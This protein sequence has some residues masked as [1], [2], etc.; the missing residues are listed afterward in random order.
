MV[1][2]HDYRYTCRDGVLTVE[3]GLFQKSPTLSLYKRSLSDENCFPAPQGG[4]A[5]RVRA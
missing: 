3:N 4:A 5:L 1:Q 2:I